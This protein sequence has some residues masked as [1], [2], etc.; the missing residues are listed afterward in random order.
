M[1]KILGFLAAGCML[2]TACDDKLDIKPLGKTTLDNVTDIETLL[3]QRWLVSEPSDLLTVCDATYKRMAQLST[4]MSNRNE[5]AYALVN[6]D[7]TINRADLTPTNSKYSGM[8]SYI[9]YANVIISK[10]PGVSGD[11]SQKPRIIAEGRILR[12][13]FHFL[14][15]N[16][17][18]KQYD[19]ATA[20]KL[21]GIP[22]VDN[23]NVQEQKTKLS[24]KEVYDR[25]LQDCSDDVIANLYQRTVDDPCRFGADFGYGVRARVLFQMKRYDEAL[26]Y[27]NLAMKINGEIEDRSTIETSGKW[28]LWENSP[29]NYLHIGS[30]NS[31]IGEFGY[32]IIPPSTY[33]KYEDG[34]YV[35]DFTTG[36]DTWDPDYGAMYGYE[37]CMLSG[38]WDVHMNAWGLRTEQMCYIAAE[39]LI[40]KGQYREGLSMVDKVRVNRIHP[41]Y[42][43]PFADKADASMTEADAMKLLRDAKLIETI[44]TFEPFF[45]AKRWNSEE[46]YAADYTRDLG[47]DYGTRTISPDSPL[48]VFPFPANATNYNSS[49]TQNY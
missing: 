14:L 15:V 26:K 12:A 29:N 19:E 31:N 34:D 47:P 21:G 8:Y 27:A 13:W 10:T 24:I 41:F 35:R 38:I 33:E 40:R 25:I 44:P 28:E 48:W 2:L 11:E 16:I 30:D 39:S 20:D 9:N 5:V 49:L 42:Y 1:K 6:Y 46:A 32:I 18:A 45:D 7:E 3:N 37:G 23:T 43:E 22:Y 36:V 4:T 17:F